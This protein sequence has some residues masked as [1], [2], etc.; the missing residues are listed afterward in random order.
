MFSE[1]EWFGQ[2]AAASQEEWPAEDLSQGRQMNDPEPASPGF[3]DRR[4]YQYMADQQHRPGEQFAFDQRMPAPGDMSP[5]REMDY[6]ESA[7]DRRQ[8]QYMADQQH[9]PGEQFAFD[10][11]MPSPKP[12]NWEF[13][14]VNQDNDEEKPTTFGGENEVEFQWNDFEP[15][16]EEDPQNDAAFKENIWVNAF[17]DEAQQ[18]D[19]N[20][21]DTEEKIAFD[22]QANES[23]GDDTNEQEFSPHD[24]VIQFFNSP[25]DP[26]DA[27]LQEVDWNDRDFLKVYIIIAK[28][29]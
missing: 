18:N 27:T 7:G 17:D 1:L 5:G 11:R 8:Y 24:L 4:Q 9:R 15:H 3:G 28:D 20:E 16:A 10:Q 13:A 14:D 21:D 25:G 22:E 2:P 29:V 23:P 19:F 26:T 6:Q 12:S